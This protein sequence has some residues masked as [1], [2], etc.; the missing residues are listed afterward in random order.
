M[1]QALAI[2]LAGALAASA[3]ASKA[4][5]FAL[6]EGT[7]AFALA[8][9]LAAIIPALGPEMTTVMVKAKDFTITSAEVIQ[10]IRDNLGTRTDGLKQVD[11]GQLKQILEQGANTLAERKLL[12]AAAKEAKAV[13]PAGDLETALQSEYGQAGGEQ[14]FLEEAA[15]E[16]P[17]VEGEQPGLAQFRGSAAHLGQ[18]PL[19]SAG[20]VPPR[21]AGS[22]PAPRPAWDGRG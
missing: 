8:K 10:A 18:Q 16:H 15:G 3:C 2:I 11:A 4:E 1:K 14:A 6:K 12:L 20:S 9:D 22:P 5:K 21:P 7:P 19:L 13:V 17:L